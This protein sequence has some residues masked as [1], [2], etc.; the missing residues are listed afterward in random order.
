M[1]QWPLGLVRCSQSW[2]IKLHRSFIGFGVA[3]RKLKS[4]SNVAFY[5]TT[6]DHMPLANDSQDFGYCL[7]VLHHIPNTERAMQIC[8]NK[9]KPGAPFL[10]YMYYNFENRPWWFRCIWKCSDLLRRCICHLPHFLKRCI[11]DSIALFVYWPLAKLTQM[12]EKCSF[13]VRHIP[14]S[15]HRGGSFYNMRNCALDRF[16]TCL[17][18]RFS[19]AD[20]VQMMKR[21]GLHNIS[22]STNPDIN[23][24]VVAYKKE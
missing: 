4:F 18:K 20:I 19:K 9:L 23:W 24:C 21:C 2:K 15:A 11:T 10:A 22:F 6:I 13:D 17:E 1:R 7:G 8:V 5:N 14:L 3:K 12:L 16:G